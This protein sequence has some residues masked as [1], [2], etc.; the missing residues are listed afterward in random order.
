MAPPASQNASEND[1]AS[2]PD[3]S[4]RGFVAVNRASSNESDASLDSRHSSPPDHLLRDEPVPRS[5]SGTYPPPHSQERAG[6]RR[7]RS[8]SGDD[9]PYLER[10]R[11]EYSPR[12]GPEPQHMANR[13]LRVLGS[14]DHNATSAYFQNDANQ[15]GHTWHAEKRA[16]PASSVNGRRPSTSESHHGETLQQEA[17]GTEAQPSHWGSDYQPRPNGQLN[18]DQYGHPESATG[19]STV[20]PKRKR[21]FSNRTKT[22]CMT[23]RQRK[24]K[25]DEGQPYCN[26]C[27]RGGFSCKGYNLNRRANPPKPTL[28]RGPIPLQSRDG[29][30]DVSEASPYQGPHME[31]PGTSNPLKRQDSVQSRPSTVGGSEGQHPATYELSPQRNEPATRPLRPNQHNPWPPAQGQSS[32]TSEHLPPL[33]DLSRSELHPS[34]NPREMSRVPPQSAGYPPSHAPP[35]PPPPPPPAPSNQAPLGPHHQQHFVPQHAAPQPVGP[36]VAH[37]PPAGPPQ[38]QLQWHQPQQPA[39]Y[40]HTYGPPPPGPPPAHASV[41]SHTRMTSSSTSFKVSGQEDVEKSKMLRSVNYIHMDPTLVYE[42]QRCERA[43]QRYNAACQLDSGIGEQEVRNLLMKVLDPSQDTTH[44]FPSQF[45]GKGYLGI[46]VK[47]ETPFTCTYGYN[48]RIHDDVYVG[49]GC[50][51]D[52]A[53]A[54]EIGPRTIIGPGVTILTSDHNKDLVNRKGTKGLWIANDVLIAAGVIIGAK[55]IIYPGVKIDEGAT[56]EPGV[57]VRESLRTNQILRAPPAQVIDPLPH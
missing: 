18:H 29:P 34:A 10:R 46:G 28:N 21:N 15:N 3:A 43:L 12:E 45:H 14:A 17:N 41:P 38:Q 57:L 7:K 16:Q 47:I 4:S 53:G 31:T 5:S 33:S 8:G 52:D 24:K 35:A 27:L 32:Y 42:R 6:H 20:A 25:C 55:A 44:R 2:S 9:E 19:A 26:N 36:S 37:Q 40:G 23:C 56:V 50:N 11:Y 49:K 54:I 30:G 13:A 22:G 39:S 1:V 51:F 48:L